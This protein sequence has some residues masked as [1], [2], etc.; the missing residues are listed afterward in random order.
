MLTKQMTPFLQRVKKV[1]TI[2]VACLNNGETI[3][4]DDM[5]PGNTSAW[6]R[7][8]EYCKENE[9]Y[10]VDLELQFRQ[11]V[12]KQPSNA[13]GYFFCKSL[14]SAMF[15]LSVLNYYSVG[16]VEDGV[17]YSQKWKVPELVLEMEHERDITETIPEALIMRIDDGK[18]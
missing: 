1:D 12:K 13:E 6:V 16:Y 9:L 11:F 3:Y 7:M 14:L 18:E 15:S 2:W 10:L 8:G 4:Q 17:I 5:V